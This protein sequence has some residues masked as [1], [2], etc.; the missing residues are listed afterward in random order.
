M[1][2]FIKKDIRFIISICFSIVAVCGS[3]F[4]GICSKKNQKFI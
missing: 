1:Q 2:Y 3:I 4:I